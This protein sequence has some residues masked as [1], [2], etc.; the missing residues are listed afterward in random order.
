[1][2][3]SNWPL[4]ELDNNMQKKD[5]NEALTFG[6]HKGVTFQPLLLQQLIVKDIIYGFGLA[7][8]LSMVHSVQGAL[9]APINIMK[10]NTNNEQEWIIPK[11]RL[12]HDQSYAWR[13]GTSINSCVWIKDLLPCHFGACIWQLVNYAVAARKKY[14]NRRILAT[15]IDYKSPYHCCHLNWLTAMKTITQLPDE[16]LAI[17][18][19]WLTFIGSPGPYKWGVISESICDLANALLLDN[20][21]NPHQLAALTSIPIKQI[22]DDYIPFGIGKDLIVDFPVDPR[23]MLDVYIDDTVGLTVNL[24]DTDNA[25][26]M[27]RAPLLAIHTAARPVDHHEPISH[28]EV[29]TR[30]KLSA[31]GALKEQKII[32]GWYF[33]LQQLTITLPEN[34]LIAWTESINSMLLTGKTTPKELEQLIGRGLMWPSGY[35][36]F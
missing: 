7:I 12:T 33:D 2:H 30:A 31:E 15:K 16:E 36:M 28:N 6:N 26:W 17:I 11:D 8:L 13:L 24:P 3:G 14:L 35:M 21:W 1:M 32:L 25:D 34:K 20:N 27:E 29:A 18:L 19:L 5:V 4:N 9:L 23:G 10:K 22:L